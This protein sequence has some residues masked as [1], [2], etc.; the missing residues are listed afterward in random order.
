MCS[1]VDGVL[2]WEQ[3]LIPGALQVIAWL[4]A[5]NK[6]FVFL[7][8]SSER[9]PRELQEKLGRLGIHVLK[10]TRQRTQQWSSV[11]ALSTCAMSLVSRDAD[12]LMACRVP[13][14]RVQVNASH[15]YTSALATASF[16]A[17]QKPNGS[18]YVIGEPGLISALYDA[19]MK[20]CTMQDRTACAPADV[21]CAM[22]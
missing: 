12:I 16:L 8:N 15:F 20:Q 17:R 13:C 1:S 3:K 7:T 21:P 6:Q 10:H 4:Q 11:I 19:G 14:V 9:S 22:T 18:A 5:N 2:Y